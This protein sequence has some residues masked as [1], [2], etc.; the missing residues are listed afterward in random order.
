M[1]LVILNYM[2]STLGINRTTLALD[3]IDDYYTEQVYGN[4]NKEFTEA[5]IS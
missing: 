2:H 5:K 1:S 3:D 4:W